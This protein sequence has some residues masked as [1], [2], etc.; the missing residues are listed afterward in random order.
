MHLITGAVGFVTGDLF[1]GNLIHDHQ[2]PGSCALTLTGDGYW[3]DDGIH[4]DVYPVGGTIDGNKIWNIDPANVHNGSST[5]L[6]IEAGNY[7]WTVK[8]NI[9]Y[10][11]GYVGILNNQQTGSGSVNQYYNNT[12]S[13]AGN[14]MGIELRWG[15]AK[16]ENNIIDVA[17]LPIYVR[18]Q[19]ITAGGITIDYNDYWDQSA[20]ASV[21]SWN[22]GAKTNLATWKTNCNC[23]AHSISVDP[24]FVSVSTPDFHLQST[25]PAINIGT[26][27]TQVTA[28]FDGIA[29]PQGPAYD[30]GAYE[31]H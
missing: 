17:H 21:G 19:A 5:G 25:S 6:H 23:D 4:G 22:E 13:G 30:M 31:W 7:G 29:R 28:D 15:F 26:T 3:E 2:L 20:G 27:L 24:K 11:I 10:N 18:S 9:I 1:K 12:I 16:V 8:N 14:Q